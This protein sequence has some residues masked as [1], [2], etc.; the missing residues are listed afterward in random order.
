MYNTC[1]RSGI[2]YDNG[3]LIRCFIQ[4]LD[5]NFDHT[6]KII[7]LGVLKWYEKILKKVLVLVNDI[8]INKTS[9]GTLITNDATANVTS[10]KQGAKRPSDTKVANSIPIQADIPQYLYKLSELSFKE[11]GIL[12]ESYA[13][14]LYQKNN[15][16]FHTC[17]ALSRTYGISLKP[18]S[19]S[20]SPPNPNTD[21]PQTTT[22][23]A[24][25]A[26]NRVTTSVNIL[27]DVS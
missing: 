17:H 10:G 2:H 7:D 1:T 25:A 9:H 26:A 12:L 22:H 19:S 16:A 15:H 18:Q 5:V 20:D 21:T 14:P 4:G 27:P 24:S 8:K 23:Q 13:C 3:F 6:C 11:V